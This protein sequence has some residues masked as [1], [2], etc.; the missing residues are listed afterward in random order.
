M[1]SD[2]DIIAHI[3][4]SPQYVAAMS[5]LVGVV[6][7]LSQ[8][9]DID[10]IGA[11]VRTAARELTGAD[12]ATFVLRDGDKCHYADEDAIEPLWKGRRFSLEMCISGWVMLNAKPVMIEDIYLDERIPAEAYRPTFVKSLAMVPVRRQAPIAAIGNYWASNR[13]A[14]DEEMAILQALADTTSVALENARLYGSLVDQVALLQSQQARIQAQHESLEVFT[15]ALAHDLKEPVRTVRAFSDLIANYDD[16]PETKSAYFELIRKSADRMT[17]LVDTVFNYTQL[18][19]PSRMAKAPC[20]ITNTVNAATGNLAQLIRE[21]H[22][23]VAIAAD[24]PVVEAHAAHIMQV[25]QNLIAN[26]VRHNEPDVRVRVTCADE[27][28]AWRFS[29]ADNG[30]G[31]AAADAERIFEPFKRLNLN[32]EGAGLGLASCR[33]IVALHGGRIW[34]ENG[35]DGGA[36]FSFTLPKPGPQPAETDATTA[37]PETATPAR[38]MP[39]VSLANVLLVDDREADVELTRVFLKV[40]DKME[41]NLS[42]ARGGQEALDMLDRAN[43]DGNPIDMVLLD[44]NM[45]GMDGFETLE[46]L[47]AHAAHGDTV[48]VMCTGSTYDKDIA[49]AR[50]LG[51]TGYMVKPA[52]LDQLRP[53]LADMPA[54]TLEG[55]GPPRRLLRA[56]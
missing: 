45:P 10:A 50:E 7:A 28:N 44:I 17:M 52:S 39:P 37:A 1:T 21:N 25:F 35:E 48:V 4:P 14:S 29:V 56:A 49:R 5:H 13:R 20:A 53:M 2:P 3:A 40:R 38:D 24:L 18:D 27:G 6:Q 54:L 46:R 42:V 30:R 12:G 36:V 32:E 41:F 34:Y 11:I 43:D 23:E 19:D 55:N 9:R 31:I 8:A 51:A 15:R 47:R 26:A 33:K 22:A 16:P